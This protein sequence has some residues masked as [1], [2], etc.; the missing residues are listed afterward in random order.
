MKAELPGPA[1]PAR[2]HPPMLAH[3]H[4]N[5]SPYTEGILDPLWAW[6]L[7]SERCCQA[8]PAAD[9]ARENNSP[10]DRQ[11]AAQYVTGRQTETGV[12]FQATRVTG[13]AG[14]IL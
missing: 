1:S 9:R 2:I 7:I 3:T 12:L 5:F 13:S 6:L 11:Q 10:N 8:G 14:R 4:T